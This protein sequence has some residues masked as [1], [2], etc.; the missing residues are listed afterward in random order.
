MRRGGL[1]RKE[2]PGLCV[3][4]GSACD[5]R[6]ARLRLHAKARGLSR[7]PRCGP[8]V[9]DPALQN[10]ETHA[11]VSG[12]RPGCSVAWPAQTEPPPGLVPDISRASWPVVGGMSLDVGQ[13]HTSLWLGG[14]RELLARASET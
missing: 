8:S 1:N 6:A 12:P 10:W 4:R 14:R 5:D 3:Q 7:S 2:T 11:P 13:P 9:L